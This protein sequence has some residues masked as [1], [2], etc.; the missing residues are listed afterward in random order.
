MLNK[1]V[2][3]SNCFDVFS[4]NSVIKTERCLKG[5][6]WSVRNAEEEEMRRIKKITWKTEYRG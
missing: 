6:C 3:D 4:T 5:S 2:K 1:R